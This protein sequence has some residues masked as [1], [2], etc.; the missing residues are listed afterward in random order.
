MWIIYKMK[1]IDDLRY[2]IQK[3]L[4]KDPAATSKWTVFFTYPHIKA[5]LYH[6]IAHKLYKKNLKGLARYISYRT[7]KKTGIEIHPG[8]QIGKGLFIDHGMGVVIGETAIIKDDVL[9]YH[10]VTLGAIKLSHE[11]R[12]PTIENN[13]LIGAGSKI[14]GDI[15]IGENSKIGCNVVLKQ[16]IPANSVVFETKPELKKQNH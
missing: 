1:I 5:L 15:T 13:V 16:S 11:K 4:E 10:G 9:I 12:H 8:A 3:T 7:R 2:N 14:L 6:R